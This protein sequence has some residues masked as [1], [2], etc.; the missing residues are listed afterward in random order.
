MAYTLAQ[1][2][3]E[4]AIRAA[5]GATRPRLLALVVRDGLAMSVAGIA[6][7]SALAWGTSGVLRA[8]LFEVSATDGTVFVG[9]ALGLG[10]A[11]LA[12]YLL[13]ATRA[14]RVEPVTALRA[15]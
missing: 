3:R 11:T 7:G 15:D 5:V 13:P 14:V 9:A 12:G 4:L 8:L 1:R 10:V 2:E 6:A